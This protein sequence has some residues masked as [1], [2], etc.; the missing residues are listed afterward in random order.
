MKPRTVII[1]AALLAIALWANALNQA[2]TPAPSTDKA[3]AC[4]CCNKTDAANSCCKDGK[5]DGQSCCKDAAACKDC[6]AKMAK[7]GQACCAGKDGKSCPMMAKN[8]KKKGCCGG[9]SC[10]MHG[11]AAG[12]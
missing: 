8:D 7:D 3:A 9:D 12:K 11:Q 5:C 6:C 10:P 1:V 2:S 4:A